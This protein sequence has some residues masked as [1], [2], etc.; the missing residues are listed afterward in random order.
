MANIIWEGDKKFLSMFRTIMTHANRNT[1]LQ[2]LTQSCNEEAQTEHQEEIYHKSHTLKQA[3]CTGGWC[4][5][6]FGVQDT[7]GWLSPTTWSNFWLVLKWSSSWTWWS[8]Q[9]SYCIVC[10]CTVLYCTVPHH[11]RFY[12]IVLYSVLFCAL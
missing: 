9:F 8:F 7:F 11:T 12:Y 4:S 1:G 2:P 5:M 6:A 10:Y 3:S